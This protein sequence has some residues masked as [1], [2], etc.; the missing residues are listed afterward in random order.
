M[1]NIEGD[2]ETMA[3]MRSS[4][5][6]KV[7]MLMGGVQTLGHSMETAAVSVVGQGGDALQRL[8]AELQRIGAMRAQD[9]EESDGKMQNS[10]AQLQEGDA[11]MSHVF[12]A[13]NDLAL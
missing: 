4:M 6:T 8:G 1:S 10:S 5:N 12:N 11:D 7:D 3:S 13:V 9:Q 2:L